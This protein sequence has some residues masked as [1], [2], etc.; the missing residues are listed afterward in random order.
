ML[1]IATFSSV[2]VGYGLRSVKTEAA[3][4]MVLPLVYAIAFLLIAD[5]DSPRGGIIHVEPQN[6]RSVLESLPPK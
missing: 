5:I 4:M 2:L 6:L 3:L 1:A